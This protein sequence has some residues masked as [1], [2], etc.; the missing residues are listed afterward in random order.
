MPFPCSIPSPGKGGLLQIEISSGTTQDGTD[1]SRIS[2]RLW[3]LNIFLLGSRETRATCRSST[4]EHACHSVGVSLFYFRYL[5]HFL[6]PLWLTEDPEECVKCK[7]INNLIILQLAVQL[8]TN[9]T[10]IYLLQFIYYYISHHRGPF[11]ISCCCV[12][13]TASSEVY[14]C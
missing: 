11:S 3:Q 6:L 1:Y 2:E 10:R 14:F 9:N 8:V 5:S 13:V 4:A 12:F 7:F